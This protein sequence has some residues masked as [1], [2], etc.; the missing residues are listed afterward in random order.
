MPAPKRSPK[1][2]YCYNA[3]SYPLPTSNIP[4]KR[5]QKNNSTYSTSAS[6]PY[7][8]I[9]GCMLACTKVELQDHAAEMQN[10]LAGVVKNAEVTGT[11]GNEIS[12]NSAISTCEKD[13]QRSVNEISYNSAISTCEKDQQCSEAHCTVER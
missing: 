8:P 5:G 3:A 13:Q 10:T 9:I 2:S 1:I 11:G 7:S 6:T 12:C 4:I